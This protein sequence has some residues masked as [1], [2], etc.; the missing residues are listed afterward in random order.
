MLRGDCSFPF[1]QFNPIPSSIITIRV[2]EWMVVVMH[3]IHC[4]MERDNT[5]KSFVNNQRDCVVAILLSYTPPT[6]TCL[7]CFSSTSV[8]CITISE[9]IELSS[10][11][12]VMDGF[13]KSIELFSSVVGMNEQINDEKRI[14]SSTKGEGGGDEAPF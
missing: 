3:S 10:A 12:G 5:T 6:T 7:L 1:T 8:C 2:N 14:H 11:F 4:S 13:G 9:E